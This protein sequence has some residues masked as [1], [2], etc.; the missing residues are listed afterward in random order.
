MVIILFCESCYRVLDVLELRRFYT[1][2]YL[3]MPLLSESFSVIPNL[4]IFVVLFY[5]GNI[6]NL[7]KLFLIKKKS[8]NVF[9]DT[10]EKIIVTWA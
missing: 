3:C 8:L 1:E 10:F 5:S 9:K 2:N 4:C 6:R 7:D